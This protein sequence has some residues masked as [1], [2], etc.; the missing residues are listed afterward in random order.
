MKTYKTKKPISLSGGE[1]GLTDDQY[2]RRESTG[3]LKKTRKKGI[4]EIVDS[5]SF[6]AGEV[7]TFSGAVKALLEVLELIEEKKAVKK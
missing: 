4:Y 7:F 3:Q 2:K 5:V 6:K 1:V